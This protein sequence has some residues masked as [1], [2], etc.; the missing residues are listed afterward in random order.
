MAKLKRLIWLRQLFL[1]LLGFLLIISLGWLPNQAQ[2]AATTLRVA[3]EPTFPPFEMKAESGEG[4]TGFDVDLMRAI[5][6]EAG[7]NIQFISLPFDGIIPALQSQ[8]VDAAIS[9]MTI[10]A[11]RAQTVDFSR[12]YFKAG[13]AIAVR[14][15]EEEIQSFEDLANQKIAVQIGTTGARETAKI[16]GV[17]ISTFDSASLALQELVN[18]KVNAVV[19]DAPVTLYAIKQANLRGIKIVGELVTEEYYGIAFPKNSPNV[20]KINTALATLLENGTYDSIY[21]TWFA[22]EAPELPAAIAETEAET[23][24][25]LEL[26]RLFSNL[27]LGAVVTLMLTAVSVFFGSVVGILIAI[28]LISPYSPLRWLCRAY[29]EF[30]R[31]TPLLVQIFMIYFGLPALLQELGINFSFERFPAAVTALSLNLGAYLAEI[32]RGGIQ[33]IEQ[34]QWEASESLGMG[35]VQTMRYVIFPQ[36]LRR[37]L[38]PLSNE[39]ITLLK[40]TSLV[41]IIG[42]EELFRQGQLIVATTYRAFEVYAAVAL[43]YLL[44]TSL[45]AASFRWLENYLNPLSKKNKVKV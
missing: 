23:S 10:T 30:F 34:G 41:A 31:G 9:G 6:K 3:T 8:T 12:P 24:S 4:L 37:I 36:A 29:V 42:F 38:P 27:L 28:A 19:N 1:W 13:L 14:E 16:P 40:D 33:S 18:G 39:F 26:G 25:P 15:N 43:V 2:E 5:G 45:A 44:L 11:E 22:G 32:I 17:E 7:L 20:A 21:Q 35:S